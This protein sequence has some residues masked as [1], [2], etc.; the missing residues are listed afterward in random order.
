MGDAPQ[1]GTKAAIMLFNG[2][3]QQAAYDKP[4]KVKASSFHQSHHCVKAFSS[5]ISGEDFVC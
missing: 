2:I 1:L 5:H 3:P 4:E